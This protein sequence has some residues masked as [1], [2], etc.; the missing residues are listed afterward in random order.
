MIEHN[1]N[2][3]FVK[4]WPSVEIV[5]LYMAGGWWKDSY[6][7]SKLPALINGSY[8]FAVVINSSS[9]KA[10]GMGRILSDGISDAYLQDLI[11]LPEYRKQGLGQKLV[12]VLI[13]RCRSQGIHWIGLIAEPGQN[14]FYES[15]GFKLMNKYTPMLYY[16]E[17]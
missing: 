6:D 8:A 17:G 3:K 7:S 10:I 5:N 1:I 9:G 13:D 15:L 2:I 16:N 14:E 4:S 12:R 11:I